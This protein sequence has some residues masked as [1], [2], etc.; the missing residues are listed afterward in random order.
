MVITALVKC[1]LLFT[2]VKPIL[3]LWDSCV[4]VSRMVISRCLDDSHFEVNGQVHIC[5]LFFGLYLSPRET[6][7]RLS[8]H[9]TCSY[10]ESFGSWQ[11]LVLLKLFFQLKQ[12][13][14]CEGCTRPP[15]L[16]EEGMLRAATCNKKKLMLNPDFIINFPLNF[17]SQ[18]LFA[19]CKHRVISEQPVVDIL[20]SRYPHLRN[21]GWCEPC[22]DRNTFAS[23]PWCFVTKKA[24]NSPPSSRTHK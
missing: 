3:I 20:N 7:L 1:G 23:N 18:S 21:C 6:Y 15:C 9:K 10:F 11:I 5:F 2:C 17:V 12:L 22:L 13:L 16:S 4:I 24:R 8:E 19:R 14:T